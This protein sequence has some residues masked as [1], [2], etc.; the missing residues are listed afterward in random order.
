MKSLG[1]RLSH[2]AIRNLVLASVVAGV[3]VTIAVAFT[4]PVVD[5]IATGNLTSA[6][7][8]TALYGDSEVLPQAGV[9]VQ[10]TEAAPVEP[11]SMSY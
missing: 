4:P 3:I 1:S 9:D 8:A 7:L 2:T 6:E 10:K 11:M 5:S